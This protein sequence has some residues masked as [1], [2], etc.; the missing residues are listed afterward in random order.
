MRILRC[1]SVQGF[2]QNIDVSQRGFN[3]I[4]SAALLIGSR[5]AKMKKEDSYNIHMRNNSFLV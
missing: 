3:G 1:E 4:S 5:K 2:E